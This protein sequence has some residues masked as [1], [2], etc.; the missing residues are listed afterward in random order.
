M[1]FKKTAPNNQR[2]RLA[3]QMGPN[4]TVI[5]SDTKIVGHIKDSQSLRIAGHIEGQLTSEGILWIDPQGYIEGPIRA[6]G[7]IVQGTTHGDIVSSEKTELCSGC[8]VTGN[9][10]CRAIAVAEDCQFQGQIQMKDN[11]NKPHRFVNKRKDP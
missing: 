11:A 10:S 2:R 5:A 4:E 7:V 3:D 6:R 1:F 8:Q 9:I